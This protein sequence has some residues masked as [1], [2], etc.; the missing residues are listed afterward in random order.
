[1]SRAARVSAGQVMREL[2]EALL[3]DGS[4]M[5]TED[6]ANAV[7]TT[8]RAVMGPLTAMKKEAEA[9]SFPGQ[10]VGNTTPTMW[11][12]TAAVFIAPRT[13]APCRPYVPPRP[14]VI[15]VRAG[16]ALAPVV[17]DGPGIGMGHWTRNKFSPTE[18]YK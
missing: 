9:V 17:T 10:R 15:P 6:I 12:S 5:S 7:G 8:T 11:R 2:I 16:G 3:S 14:T 4:A 13:A 1:M 18:T